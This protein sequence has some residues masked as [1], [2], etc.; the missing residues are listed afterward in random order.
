MDHK[1]DEGKEMILTG[2]D[3]NCG[4]E[5]GDQGGEWE[6]SKTQQKS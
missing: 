3:T 6:P 4:T 2:S 5:I 1:T